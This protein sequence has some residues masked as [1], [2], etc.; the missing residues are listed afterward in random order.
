MSSE[1]RRGNANSSTRARCHKTGPQTWSQTPYRQ[2][3]TPTLFPSTQANLKSKLLSQSRSQHQ[4]AVSERD[5]LRIELGRFGS[6]F[7]DRQSQV[8]EQIAEVGE[9]HYGAISGHGGGQIVT[10]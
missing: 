5:Q 10:V 4:S 7:R 9:A 2:S 1:A 8:D 6:S 3:T